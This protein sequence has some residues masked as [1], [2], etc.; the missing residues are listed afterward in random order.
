[1]K[2]FAFKQRFYCIIP[3]KYS[4]LPS[5]THADKR[6]ACVK[7]LKRFIE[8]IKSQTWQQENTRRH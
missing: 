6:G 3:K 8:E 1:M 7:K 2:I 4:L 5:G